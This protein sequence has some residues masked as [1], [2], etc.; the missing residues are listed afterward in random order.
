MRARRLWALLLLG[1]LLTGCGMLAA[2]DEDPCQTADLLFSDDFT[3]DN[4]CGWRL[5]DGAGVSAEIDTGVLRLTVS[6]VGQV[7][8]TTTGRTYGDVDI[9][10]DAAQIAGP[11]NNAYGIICRYQDEENYYIFLISGDGYYAI[12]KYQSDR[13]Q[14]EYL[15]GEGPFF[16]QS[17]EFINQGATANTIRVRCAGDTLSLAVGGI[18]IDEVTDTTFAEGD[19]GVAAATFEADAAVIEFDNVRVAAP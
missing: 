16:Y 12:G 7:T 1:V 3:E 2:R 6:N 11:N 10:V 4:L 17:S 9:A 14:V 13:S 8:W 18:L 15:T 5:F 19:V